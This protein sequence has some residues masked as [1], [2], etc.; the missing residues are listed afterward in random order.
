VR[1]DL[2]CYATLT[3][4]TSRHHLKTFRAVKFASLSLSKPSRANPLA[5]GDHTLPRL[6]M[7]GSIPPLLHTLLQRAQTRARSSLFATKT[8]RKEKQ[9]IY[10]SFKKKCGGMEIQLHA[11]LTCAPDV[12]E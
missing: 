3:T 2:N 11:F 1:Y 6:R 8:Y 7:G 9:T 4:R 5:T 10:L 12:C